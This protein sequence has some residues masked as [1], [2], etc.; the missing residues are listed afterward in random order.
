LPGEAFPPGHEFR[1][2][3]ST[4][5][6]FVLVEKA[7]YNVGPGRSEDD[8]GV[9]GP[10][11]FATVIEHDVAVENDAGGCEDSSIEFFG[12][13]SPLFAMVCEYQPVQML[14]C[15]NDGGEVDEVDVERS[16]EAVDDEAGGGFGTRPTLCELDRMVLPAVASGALE[17]SGTAVDVE[18]TVGPS[19]ADFLCSLAYALPVC[20]G[21]P[22]AQHCRGYWYG[23][24]QQ[25]RAWWG[26]Q[27]EMRADKMITRAAVAAGCDARDE[28]RVEMDVLIEVA[29]DCRHYSVGGRLLFFALLFSVSSP[30]N[31]CFVNEFEFSR[32]C[33]TFL[34]SRCLM[35]RVPRARVRTVDMALQHLDEETC[36]SERRLRYVR[37]NALHDDSSFRVGSRHSFAD[38]DRVPS[39]MWRGLCASSQ[40]SLLRCLRSYGYC[41]R[42]GHGLAGVVSLDA[43]GG[44]AEN[45]VECPERR[46]VA[47]DLAHLDDVDSR[48]LLSQFERS[49]VLKSDQLRTMP[50]RHVVDLLGLSP[51][52]DA[53][54]SF[55]FARFEDLP[56]FIEDRLWAMN[57]ADVFGDSIGF[58][59]SVGGIILFFVLLR[60]HVR[61]STCFACRARS[62]ICNSS[63]ASDEKGAFL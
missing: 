44:I 27:D 9:E 33:L 37:S 31:V 14:V 2:D 13:E 15:E 40:R 35:R 12:L 23:G 24:C 52:E 16:V 25:H 56:A 55:S 8:G 46:R 62:E 60:R 20:C 34:E 54:S 26:V 19:C 49:S 48:S 21:I 29:L 36:V 45:D 43:I 28:M 39:G 63:F 7:G 59:L 5:E 42:R 6:Q 22:V 61:S 30:L 17:V 53:S 41:R 32:S 11:L 10:V 57:M 50:D 3:L 38:M 4:G 47:S 51:L 1:M 58:P 18:F